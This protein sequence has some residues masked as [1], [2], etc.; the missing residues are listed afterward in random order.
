MLSVLIVF[1]TNPSPVGVNQTY[2]I[3]WIYTEGETPNNSF[4]IIVQ[5]IDG[6]QYTVGIFDSSGS[7]SVDGPPLSGTYTLAAYSNVPGSHTGTFF[8]MTFSAQDA[9]SDTTPS[10][11]I[12]SD[13]TTSTI[14]S[15]ASFATPTSATTSTEKTQRSPPLS[16]SPT[17]MSLSPQQTPTTLALSS[18][19]A[20]ASSTLGS[21]TVVSSSTIPPSAGS[22]SSLASSSSPRTLS[23]TDDIIIGVFLGIALILGCLFAYRYYLRR[24]SRQ[25]TGR[26]AFSPYT[27][28][29][30]VFAPNTSVT[31]SSSRARFYGHQVKT[32]LPLIPLNESAREMRVAY[33]PAPPSYIAEAGRRNV[34]VLVPPTG[35]NKQQAGAR[36]MNDVLLADTP[37]SFKETACFGY[38]KVMAVIATLE[39]ERFTIGRD[40][41]EEQRCHTANIP[42]A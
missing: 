24:K 17:L 35:T 29:S 15:F 16:S 4:G 39:C 31:G 5:G 32:R 37:I 1:S 18:T 21:A 19:D 6:Y 42:Q 11:T 26:T 27:L 2:E 33:E 7:T 28:A 41:G 12:T 13:D 20:L 3:S 38:P 30:P 8:T 22:S 23:S 9:T 40:P 10:V 25:S 14:T 34:R 36:T